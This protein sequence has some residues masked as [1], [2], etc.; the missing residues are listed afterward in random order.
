MVLRQDDAGGRHVP[1]LR[2]RRPLGGINGSGSDGDDLT[3]LTIAHTETLP[4]W[5]PG[6]QPSIEVT[7]SIDPHQPGELPIARE[8]F[9]HRITA[10]TGAELADGLSDAAVSLWFRAARRRRVARSHAAPA[11]ETEIVID[12]TRE[13]FVMVGE[14]P[15]PWVAVRRHH[16]VMITIAARDIDPASLVIEPIAHPS[17]RLLGP[18]PNEP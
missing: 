6:P 2:G 7:T 8:A 9:T 3:K 11:G 15:T 4:H 1:H 17:A 18:E 12:G 10:D 5:T 14:I 13:P 16:D